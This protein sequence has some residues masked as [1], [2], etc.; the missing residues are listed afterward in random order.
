VVRK[1]REKICEHELYG[2]V[3]TSS[4]TAMM[5]LALSLL[6]SVQY[7]TL[8]SFDTARSFIERNRGVISKKSMP[9]RFWLARMN[10]PHFVIPG[11]QLGAT[12]QIISQQRRM[13]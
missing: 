7:G 11:G 10:A 2:R 13:P 1:K 4:I 6:S 9:I 5:I 8:F 12:A 3:S